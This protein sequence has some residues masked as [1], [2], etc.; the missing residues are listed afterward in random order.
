MT[1]RAYG[2]L[3]I[4]AM[5]FALY[6]SLLPFRF[7]PVPIRVAAGRFERIMRAESRE[8]TSRGNFIANVLLFVPV[9]FALTGALALGRDRGARASTLLAVLPIS[10]GA[11][12]TAEFLQS[13]VPGRVVSRYD[14]IAQTI[15]CGIGFV[16]WVVAGDG[17]TRA[18]QSASERHRGDRLARF[19][20]AYA[21]G[22]TLVNL[23]PFDATV[24]LG[25]LYRRYRD[26][27][28]NLVPFWY[29]GGS[30]ALLWDACVTA[31]AAVPLGALGLIGWTGR[32]IRRHSTTAVLF[33]ASFV[34]GIELAH[35]FIRQ[36]AADINDVLWGTAGVVVGVLTARRLLS[37]RSAQAVLPP[38]VCSGRAI[39]L[40]VLW[41]GVLC[42]YHW[43]PFDFSV[44]VDRM[45][46]IVRGTSL[47]PFAAYRDGSELQVFKHVLV[48]IGLALPFGAIAAFVVRPGA[49]SEWL[50][51]GAWIAVACGAFAGIEAGQLFLPARTPDPTDALV[52]AAAA[53][54][55]LWIGRRV[56]A[57]LALDRARLQSHG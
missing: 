41:T 9:G 35:V 29:G 20:G 54:A 28:I 16:L 15:G 4:A 10:L 21:I 11:S 5:A 17:I 8:W 19:L 39:A 12:L 24:D 44:D 56:H 53:I 1:R 7:E 13:F 22:W 42:V 26:G 25:V 33:G 32:A 30:R 51:R 14:V 57:G 37:G 46:A 49:A 45:R 3:A 27:Q 34:L 31:L 23:A 40:L 38:R 36:H 47:I 50:V 52:G 48:K 6:V 18:L 43:R 2:W 55:G